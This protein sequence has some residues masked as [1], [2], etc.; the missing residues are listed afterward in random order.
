ME[1][2]IKYLLVINYN[3][4]SYKLKLVAHEIY[5]KCCVHACLLF[6]WHAKEKKGHCTHGC[7]LFV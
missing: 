4:Q 2:K 3:E 1:D 5:S 6:L 7:L